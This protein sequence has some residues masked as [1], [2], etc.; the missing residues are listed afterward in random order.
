[1]DE[2]STDSNCYAQ[3]GRGGIGW[4]EK[5]KLGCSGPEITTIMLSGELE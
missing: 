5:Q 4:L 3:E 1:M 2:V